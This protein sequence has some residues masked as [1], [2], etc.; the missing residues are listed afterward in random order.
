M[1]DARP[2]QDTRLSQ[3]DAASAN[4]HL[5]AD[6]PPLKRPRV[7]ILLALACSLALVHISHG[8]VEVVINL[9]GTVLTWTMRALMVLESA[10][11]CWLVAVAFVDLGELVI[12]LRELNPHHRTA[13]TKKRRRATGER[14]AVRERIP[15]MR[16]PKVRNRRLP[17]AIWPPRVSNR[18]WPPNELAAAGISL[19]LISPKCHWANAG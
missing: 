5:P 2:R 17:R 12:R 10:F 8:M 3:E 9:T 1:L 15:L 7:G 13:K 19:G 14:K 11:L 18:Q 4:R 16:N 6:H